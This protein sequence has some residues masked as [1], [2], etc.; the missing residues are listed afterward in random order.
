[1]FSSRLLDRGGGGG[2]GVVRKLVCI[3]EKPELPLGIIV[4]WDILA[5]PDPWCLAPL[6]NCLLV[7]NKAAVITFSGPLIQHL[8][9]APTPTPSSHLSHLFC[10]SLSL[11]PLIPLL[12][13][14]S[15]TSSYYVSYQPSS[16]ALSCSSK[17]LIRD[18]SF[19]ISLTVILTTFFCFSSTVYNF[20]QMCFSC[21][22]SCDSFTPPTS[23][24]H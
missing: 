4:L 20:L 7:R 18:P 11:Y 24:S 23:S 22:S 9:S 5:G 6:H 8:S 17:F 21:V 14:F 15:Y 1:M 16:F 2:R 10:F 13:L 19:P 3:E 12:S